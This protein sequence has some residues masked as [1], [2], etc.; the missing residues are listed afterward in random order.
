MKGIP[1]RLKVEKS[2]CSGCLKGK[3]ANKFICKEQVEKPET[4]LEK[5]HMDTCGPLEV[6]GR[7]GEKGFLLI[8]DGATSYRWVYAIKSKQEIPNEIIRWAGLIEKQKPMGDK[9]NQK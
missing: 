9:E 5:L 3:Q 4:P 2:Y 1:E 8:T 6:P 7:N